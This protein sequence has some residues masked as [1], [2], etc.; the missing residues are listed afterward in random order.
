MKVSSQLV[1]KALNGIRP[2]RTPIFDLL[3]NDAVIE[4]FAGIHF[5]KFNSEKVCTT[6]IGNALDANRSRS[7]PKVEGEKWTDEMGNLIVNA[8]WTHWV[9][10]HAISSLDGWVG[11]IKKDIEKLNNEEIPDTQ[12]I[13][14]TISD[15]KAYNATLSGTVFIHCTPSTAINYILFG[16][17]CGLENFTY[18]WMDHHDLTLQWIRAIEAQQQR[19]IDLT[20]HTQTS[21]MVMI[22]SDIAFKNSLAYSK[23][24]LNQMGFFDEVARICDC[25]HKKGLKVIFHSDGYLMEILNDLVASGI[26]G[27]NPIEKAAGMDVFEIRQKFPELIIVGGVDVTHLLRTGSKGD[28][29]N[30]VRK[31]ISEVGSEGRL[32]IGS[33]TELD[34]QVPLENYLTF[35]DEVMR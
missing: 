12:K 4:Y 7:R 22:Y 28:I 2:E 26:D 5:D 16:Y 17:H 18:L 32:L 21:P 33:S 14:A 19:Y 30:Q 6:A 8:R 1:N 15:Q 23:Q 27:L 31:I 25:C 35:H 24:M 20:A 34:N 13:E 29:R 3:T 9:Q 10:K 11:F